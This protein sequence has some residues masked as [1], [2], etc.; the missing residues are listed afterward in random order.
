M[1]KKQ[2]APAE[3]QTKV[4]VLTG[5]A[6]GQAND[7]AVLDAATASQAKA[8]GLVDDNAEAVA[9][10]ESLAAPADADPAL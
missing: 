9:Y 3:G 8:D 1:A 6:F 10:A 2:A 7:V 5:C 4:R